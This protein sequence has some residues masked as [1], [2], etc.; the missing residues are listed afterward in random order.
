M[1]VS[2]A[3]LMSPLLM[4]AVFLGQETSPSLLGQGDG[5]GHKGKLV[6]VS[7]NLQE[8]T[9]L[10]KL[11][12]ELEREE[13]RL[14]LLFLQEV[15]RVP[16]CE[17][18][19][20]RGLGEHFGLPYVSATSSGPE[21]SRVAPRLATLSRTPIIREKFIALPQ[22][23]LVFKSRERYALE[24]TIETAHGPLRTF[25]LHLDS[26]INRS[27][28]QLQIKPILDKA[29][30]ES[31]PVLIA[32]DLNSNDFF[33]LLHLLPVPFVSNQK[34]ALIEEFAS[35]EFTTPFDS[36]EPTHDF[37]G[38][39]L[40]WIFGRDVTWTNQGISPLDF[41][42]HHLIWAEFTLPTSHLGELRQGSGFSLHPESQNVLE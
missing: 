18:P 13:V 12:E 20:L 3:L 42:D 29:S 7:I 23:N 9:D 31:G 38:L 15:E 1:V 8:K 36:S 25:N 11:I 37:L 32:G 30:R 19:L 35:R 2:K 26:R 5:D 33:W 16:D 39:K 21:D 4:V 27:E 40:D 6:A 34:Q 14:D 22:Y 17:S 41:S 28:R 24:A 10:G